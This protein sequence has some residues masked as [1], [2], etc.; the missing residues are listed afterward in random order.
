MDVQDLKSYLDDNFAT[1]QD[2][3]RFATKQDLERFAT[4]EDLKKFATKEDLKEGLQILR[5]EF[6]QSHRHLGVL[7]E[8]MKGQF[9]VVLEA[10]EPLS[11]RIIE[12]ETRIQKLEDDI[13][14]VN[15]AV[16]R[17]K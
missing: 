4:K 17:R 14:V 6:Q 5:T 9:Q 3:E 7:F 13:I 16:T 15:M 12:H 10:L 2:L 11:P 1:K 8:E